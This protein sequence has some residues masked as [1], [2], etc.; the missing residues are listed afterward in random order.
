MRPRGRS[1]QAH[2]A[3]VDF[4][5]AGDSGTR[6]GHCSIPMAGEQSGWRGSALEIS[7]LRSAGPITTTSAHADGALLLGQVLFEAHTV[8]FNPQQ[9]Y[10]T[11]EETGARRWE[12]LAEGAYQ[13]DV[14]SG[15]SAAVRSRVHIENMRGVGEEG[16]WEPS[17]GLT[18][19]ALN[20][21]LGV[22]TS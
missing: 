7:L 19:A 13:Q 16:E 20:I 12:E 9:P 8:S 5:K 14:E 4:M 22:R 2:A 11:D 21:M 1:E 15:L 18:G 17:L 3:A 10:L 6:L